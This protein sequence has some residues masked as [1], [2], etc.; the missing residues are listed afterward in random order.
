MGHYCGFQ[1]RKTSLDILLKAHSTSLL[2]LGCEALGD[3]ARR[4]AGMLLG[5]PGERG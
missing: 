2:R 5:N 1:K 3:K 4:P